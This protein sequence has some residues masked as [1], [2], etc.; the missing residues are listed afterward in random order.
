MRPTCTSY[1]ELVLG[2]R[3]EVGGEGGAEETKG[4]EGVWSGLG[5]CGEMGSGG[6]GVESVNQTNQN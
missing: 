6:R 1:A 3:R 5:W 2:T 4:E